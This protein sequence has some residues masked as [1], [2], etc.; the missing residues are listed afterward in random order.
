MSPVLAMHS[1]VTVEHGTPHEVAALARHVL[2]R[3]DV[4]PFSNAYWNRHVIKARQFI[5]E[6]QDALDPDWEFADDE[7]FIVNPPGGM[8]REAFR[9]A[10]DRYCQGSDVFWVGFNLEQM[11]YLQRQ[12]LFYPSFRR[13]LP[14]RRLAFLR[15]PGDVADD[16]NRRMNEPGISERAYLELSRKLGRLLER[17]PDPDGPPLP[18]TQPTHSNY[19]CLMSHRSEAIERFE[20]AVQLMPAEVF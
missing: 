2:G 12:G 10:T 7:T 17:H 6:E 1:A 13:A 3:I 20:E 8:V 16:L 9:F 15:R 11:P 19:L 5:D 14:P 18:G 4:D